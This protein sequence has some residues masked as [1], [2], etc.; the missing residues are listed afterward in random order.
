VVGVW[1][2]AERLLIFAAQQ[3]R[4]PASVSV[5]WTAL[6]RRRS[7]SRAY[8][9]PRPDRSGRAPSDLRPTRTMVGLYE[10][11]V[12]WLSTNTITGKPILPRLIAST[13]TVRRAPLQIHSLFGRSSMLL[14]PLPR[15]SLFFTRPPGRIDRVGR[16]SRRASR[17]DR[18]DGEATSGFDIPRE[19]TDSSLS[20]GTSSPLDRQRGGIS[21]WRPRCCEV[22]DRR[23]RVSLVCRNLS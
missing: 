10:T 1:P 7:S 18:R 22:A 17:E 19:V 23:L 11:A 16:Q 3:P 9:N 8:F 15:R 12:E 6:R 4:G 13:A 2:G 14:F 5:R 21:T 20:A